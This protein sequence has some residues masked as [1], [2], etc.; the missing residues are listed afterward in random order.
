MST[1]YCVREA[2]P[3]CVEVV[4]NRKTSFLED[5]CL[6]TDMFFAINGV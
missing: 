4:A 6:E 1:V 3:Q 5:G 2:R